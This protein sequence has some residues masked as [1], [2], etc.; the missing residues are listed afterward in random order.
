VGDD[1]VGDLS[2]LQGIT[3][4]AGSL[5]L[6]NNDLTD[7]PALSGNESIEVLYLYDNAIGPDAEMNNPGVDTLATL[8]NLRELYLSGNSLTDLSALASLEQLELLEL[9]DNPNITCGILDELRTTF[10]DRGQDI[11]IYGQDCP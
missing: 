6:S 1:A 10:T 7:L 11:E 2:G 8:V 4:N 9:N 3:F 5:D